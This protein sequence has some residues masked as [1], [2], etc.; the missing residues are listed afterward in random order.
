MKPMVALFL[1]LA[2]PSAMAQGARCEASATS[3][4]S[5]YLRQ[6]YLDLEGRSPTLEE[7]E[8]VSSGKATVE[9]VLSRLLDGEGF[10]KRVGQFHKELLWP[11]LRKLQVFGGEHMLVPDASQIHSRAIFAL[12][13]RGEYAKSCGD[14]PA[15]IVNG[16]I[17]V[18]AQGEEG[19]VWVEPYWAKGT[20]IKVCAF[21]AQP[22]LTNS[23]GV[24]CNSPLGNRSTECGCG[25]NLNFCQ[26]YVYQAE[27]VTTTEALVRDAFEK[28]VLEIVDDVVKNN[29]PYVEVLTRSKSYLN[30]PAAHFWKYQSELSVYPSSGLYAPSIQ[31]PD[32]VYNDQGLRAIE[33][34]GLHAGVLTTPAFLIRFQTNRSRANRFSN[35]YLCSAFTPPSQGLPA[36]DSECAREP[37]LQKRCG[38]K[39]CHVG[40]EPMAASWGRFSEMGLDYHD[41]KAFPLEDADCKQCYSTGRSCSQRC[42]RNYVTQANTAQEREYVGK[43]KSSMFLSATHQT[44]LEQGPRFL[45]ERS[46]FQGKLTECIAESVWK[47]FMNRAMSAQERASLLAGFS[48]DFAASG[49]N[50]KSL[51]RSIVTSQAYR[52][53]R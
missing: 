41:P 10:R 40:L 34:G 7:Y 33:R 26:G 30:G 46:L 35:A 49:L 4:P 53:R 6:L 12:Y 45:V 36:P 13:Y 14:A 2:A 28:E 9:Q 1:M 17:Q 47:H 11:S 22:A 24:R 25:P 48:N 42:A 32:I 31:I 19:W 5:T 38:C 29:R 37:D 50:F 27:G 23:A 43:L 20:K 21:D 52:T 44:F 51:V 8:E 16:V 15:R 3:T 39:Y 18:N